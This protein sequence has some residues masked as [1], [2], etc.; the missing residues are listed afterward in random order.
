QLT[1]YLV[2]AQM[3]IG[4]TGDDHVDAFRWQRPQQGAC[5]SLQHHG[6]LVSR[7]CVATSNHAGSSSMP[8]YPRPVFLAATHT[9]PTPINGSSTTSPGSVDFSM[10]YSRSSTGFSVGCCMRFG[11]TLS[12]Y[13]TSLSRLP[14]NHRRPL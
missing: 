4:R 8:I 9:L 10:K 3:P 13:W 6:V 5:V 11:G 12:K 7:R 2:I 1:G 14:N